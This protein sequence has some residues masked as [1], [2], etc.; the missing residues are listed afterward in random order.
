VIFAEVTRGD[1]VVIGIDVG[2]LLTI[3]LSK[4]AEVARRPCFKSF[5]R[6]RDSIRWFLGSQ[7]GKTE[8]KIGAFLTIL[9]SK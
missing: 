7:A 1:C 4:K 6:F 2:C 5:L 8:L 9:S 3:Y